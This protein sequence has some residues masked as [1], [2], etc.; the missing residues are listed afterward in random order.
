[1]SV[2]LADYADWNLAKTVKLTERPTRGIALLEERY[3]VISEAKSAG[4]GTMLRSDLP[5]FQ[6]RDSADSC[7]V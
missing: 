6:D 1:M 2:D 5:S 3:S 4:V 7:V